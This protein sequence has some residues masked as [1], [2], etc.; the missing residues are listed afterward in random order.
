MAHAPIAPGTLVFPSFQRYYTT[1]STMNGIAL[2]PA[3]A[4]LAGLVSL[5]MVRGLTPP[6]PLLSALHGIL[7]PAQAQD[8]DKAPR[9]YAE[10]LV[11]GL[12]AKAALSMLLGGSERL[13]SD[14]RAFHTF[15][16]TE[17]DRVIP[18]QILLDATANPAIPGM[19]TGH[20]T[21]LM[22]LSDY[23]QQL[24]YVQTQ[25]A[26]T[27]DA[28]FQTLYAA[29]PSITSAER[30]HAFVTGYQ[31]H[32]QAAQP[33]L[34][35][36]VSS[37]TPQTSCAIVGPAQSDATICAR[38][39]VA[40][41]L[42]AL[43]PMYWARTSLPVSVI[44]SAMEARQAGSFLTEIK[45]GCLAIKHAFPTSLNVPESMV[46]TLIAP[47]AIWKALPADVKASIPRPTLVLDDISAS[48]S[49]EDTKTGV[50]VPVETSV[51]SAPKPVLHKSIASPMSFS[52]LTLSCFPFL[53]KLV[54][55]S[56][57][58][59]ALNAA[60]TGLGV[61]SLDS[62]T[63][64]EQ[65]V[66]LAR[67]YPQHAALCT[68]LTETLTA[69][70]RVF[71]EEEF[72]TDFGAMQETREMS[73]FWMDIE[74]GRHVTISEDGVDGGEILERDG[75]GVGID[76]M[77]LDAAWDPEPRPSFV[78]TTEEQ[79]MIQA[80]MAERGL[81]ALEALTVL[82]LV[83]LIQD[84]LPGRQTEI[85]AFRSEYAAWKSRD[86]ARSRAMSLDLLQERLNAPGTRATKFGRHASR[87]VQLLVTHALRQP[88]VAHPELVLAGTLL[89]DGT[90]I[91]ISAGTA[92]SGATSWDHDHPLVVANW[93]RQ[94]SQDASVFHELTV[95]PSAPD[96]R[97]FIGLTPDAVLPSAEIQKLAQGVE[98]ALVRE[99][100]EAL[101]ASD[102]AALHPKLE[103]A[104][105]KVA[106]DRGLDPH[107]LLQ[108]V[109][110][111]IVPAWQRKNQLYTALALAFITGQ[112]AVV[113][114]KRIW[115]T[116]I[117]RA[118]KRAWIARWIRPVAAV[119]FTVQ[120][121]AHWK[122]RALAWG[123]ITAAE[124]EA[125]VRSL[126]DFELE[127][128]RIRLHS[129]FGFMS[130]KFGEQRITPTM[131]L[132]TAV[133]RSRSLAGSGRGR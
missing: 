129:A 35:R 13:R 127:F 121:T 12:T 79:A 115:K 32:L 106:A 103:A 87:W 23:A 128:L 60:L 125:Y 20:L 116:R 78:F 61:R 2:T 69:Q 6:A 74:A 52:T 119:A 29:T 112:D 98:L 41:W 120:Q 110:E 96:S 85:E 92:P 3:P 83:S 62:L 114:G 102:E 8:P 50:L 11:K 93:I 111:T 24:D 47:Q 82:D 117:R 107:V 105:A 124:A 42:S 30:I 28:Y 75:S 126:P 33:V 51:I 37:I 70:T 76:L 27:R 80:V 21:H 15:V 7:A 84:L 53:A 45:R 44:R 71:G 19:I 101:W 113:D 95:D 132:G 34:D 1:Y 133:A 4:T 81:V 123:G 10:M 118:D 54:A 31:T 43:L 17:M 72:G 64:S 55:S 65:A 18:G 26:S 90:V 46:R 63:L 88:A 131:P 48:I 38:V 22:G 68:A 89:P 5:G 67:V 73:P 104:V 56:D 39:V 108:V 77:E 100:R 122:S 49:H 9:L 109:S 59:T 66:V 16:T 130:P 94:V 97:A 91:E 14:A 86:A 36:W 58:C 99:A 40:Q 25:Q 57:P